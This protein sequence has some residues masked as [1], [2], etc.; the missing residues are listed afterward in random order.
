MEDNLKQLLKQEKEYREKEN[1]YDCFQTCLKIIDTIQLKKDDYKYNILSKIFLYQNQ[2][3]YVKLSLINNIIQNPSIINSKNIKKKYYKLLIDSFSKGKDKEYQDEIN[4]LKNLYGKGDL[5]DYT[6]IDKYISNLVSETL[7]TSNQ[8]VTYDSINFTFGSESSIINIPYN[9]SLFREENNLKDKFQ[10]SFEGIITDRSEDFIKGMSGNYSSKINDKKVYEI[11]YLLKKYKPNNHLPMIIINVSTNLNSN[12]FLNLI[13]EN[14]EKNNFNNICTIKET[15]NDNIKVYEYHRKNCLNNLFSKLICKNKNSISQFQV[16]TELK[17]DEKNFDKKSNSSSNDLYERKVSIKTIKGIQKNSIKAIIQ[18][19]KDFCVD[20]DKIQIIKQSKCFL[21][22][23]LDETLKD[24]INLHKSNNSLP[25][26][27][28]EEKEEDII[29]KKNSD[30]SIGDITLVQKTNKDAERYYEM[31]KIFSQKKEGLGKT[32]YE[33]IENFKNEYKLTYNEKEDTIIDKNN[34]TINPNNIDTRS[35]MMKIINIF[36]IS[37][38]SLNSTFN[39]DKKNKM[40][41]NILF[42][43]AS[44]NFIL[45]KIYPVLYNI[46][47]LKYKKDNELYLEK[48]KEINNKLSIEEIWDKIGIK[49]KFRGRDKIPFKYVINI[50]NKINFEKSLT[51]KYEAITQSS[52]ELRNC[53]LDYTNCKYELDS[54]DDELP[55]VIYIG[56]QINIDNPYAEFFMIEDYVKCSLRDNLKENRMVTNLLS[57]LIYISKEWKFD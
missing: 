51:K 7:S 46:Y 26:P 4:K 41:N 10:N 31:Y 48:K 24:I 22:Y 5:N 16:M 1:Y 11:K 37:I 57:S 42:S 34:K 36:D 6:I 33:F 27:K 29:Q 49:Q 3:N 12:E 17:I 44:E 38:N 15:E 8:Q 25:I 47:H 40:G 54:M 56:T 19:L 9:P 13:N 23:K 30:E 28:G 18:I 45:N 32:I 50:I 55:I 52:L 21:K 2:S 35:A 14:F 20:V 53:I 39:F 43:N